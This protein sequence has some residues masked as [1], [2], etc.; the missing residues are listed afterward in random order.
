[1]RAEGWITLAGLEAGADAAAEARRLGCGHAL[2]DDRIVA[3][4][5]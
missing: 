2:I 1:L 4:A 3:L 5:D